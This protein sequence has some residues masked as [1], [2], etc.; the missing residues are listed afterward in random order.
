MEEDVIASVRRVLQQFFSNIDE[1]RETERKWY[2]CKTAVK[3]TLDSLRKHPKII[4]NCDENNRATSKDFSRW[5]FSQ[6]LRI[7]STPKCSD[8]HGD[9]LKMIDTILVDYREVVQEIIQSFLA[10]AH[11]RY[12]FA[13]E[14]VENLK[15]SGLL[16]FTGRECLVQCPT[17]SSISLADEEKCD[18]ALSVI[19]Y[20]LN[21]HFHITVIDDRFHEPLLRATGKVIEVCKPVLKGEAMQLAGSVLL[22]NSPDFMTTGVNLVV[23]LALHLMSSNQ[24]FLLEDDIVASVKRLLTISLTGCEDFKEDAF[25]PRKQCK[26]YIMPWIKVTDVLD[27]LLGVLANGSDL[28]KE[29]TVRCLC[30]I[31]STW[32]VSLYEQTNMTSSRDPCLNGNKGWT[33]MLLP[34]LLNQIPLLKQQ[35]VVKCVM[36]VLDVAD[37]KR[38]ICEDSILLLL[39]HNPEENVAYNRK[40]LS[41]KKSKEKPMEFY[42]LLVKLLGTLQLR[43]L[44]TPASPIGGN[45]AV[46]RL[47]VVWRCLVHSSLIHPHILPIVSCKVE[48][49]INTVETAMSATETWP[50][51]LTLLSNTLLLFHSDPGSLPSKVRTV[52]KRL[53][54]INIS[55]GSSLSDEDKARV[56]G[57]YVLL[58][59]HNENNLKYFIDPI[60][61]GKGK[62]SVIP[63]IQLFSQMKKTKVLDC[64]QLLTNCKNSEILTEVAINL[65]QIVLSCFGGTLKFVKRQDMSKKDLVTCL[66]YTPTQ[67]AEGEKESL[68]DKTVRNILTLFKSDN[69]STCILSALDHVTVLSSHLDQERLVDVLIPLLLHPNSSARHKLAQTQASVSFHFDI[70]VRHKLAKKGWMDLSLF[71]SSPSQAKSTKLTSSQKK[72]LHNLK[73]ALDK[74][75]DFK[76]TGLENAIAVACGAKFL[77]TKELL[78]AIMYGVLM[79]EDSATQVFVM[80]GLVKIAESQGLASKT[81]LFERYNV[82][83]CDI[84]AKR[85]LEQPDAIVSFLEEV[86]GAFFSRLIKQTSPAAYLLGRYV[87]HILPAVFHYGAQSVAHGDVARNILRTLSDFVNQTVKSLVVKNFAHIFCY[88]ARFSKQQESPF[89]FVEDV[90]GMSLSELM[91]HNVQP[92]TNQLALYL[93]RDNDAVEWGLNML[94]ANTVVKD[95]ATRKQQPGSSHSDNRNG[96][97]LAGLIEPRLLGILASLA[98]LQRGKFTEESFLVLESVIELMQIFPPHT[99]TKWKNKLLSILRNGLHCSDLVV[100]HDALTAWDTFVRVSEKKCVGPLVGEIVAVLLPHL[101]TFPSQV[102]QTVRYLLPENERWNEIKDYVGDIGWLTIPDHPDLADVKTKL[103][104]HGRVGDTMTEEWFKEC[105]KSHIAGVTAESSEVRSHS[106]TSL[107][108]LLHNN[109]K[110][111]NLMVLGRETVDKVITELISTLLCEV[112][113][114]DPDIRIL[115]CTCLGEVGAI[116]G[117]LLGSVISTETSQHKVYMEGIEDEKFG[118]D[119]LIV[120]SKGYRNSADQLTEDKFAFAIQEVLSAYRQCGDQ[121]FKKFGEKFDESVMEILEPHINSRYILNPHNEPSRASP[122]FRSEKITTFE[123]WLS[124]WTSILLQL[125][126][127]GESDKLSSLLIGPLKIITSTQTDTLQFL[128]PILVLQILLKGSSSAVDLVLTEI[129]AVLYSTQSS[130]VLCDVTRLIAQTVF[131]LIDYIVIWINKKRKITPKG[132]S[133]LL[134]RVQTTLNKISKQVISVSAFNCGAYNRALMYLEYK[135]KITDQGDWELLQMIYVKMSEF[136][137]VAGVTA[138]RNTPASLKEQIQALETEGRLQETPPMYEQGITQFPDDNFFIQ[139]KLKQLLHTGLHTTLL[140]VVNDRIK[141]NSTLTRDLNEFRVQAAWSLARWD[142]VEEYISSTPQDTSWAVGVGRQ[143][144]SARLRDKEAFDSAIRALRNEQLIPLSVAVMEGGCYER[145]YDNVL[146]LHMLRDIEEWA[147]SLIFNQSS[148][149]DADI[150]NKSREFESRMAVIQDGWRTREPV[151]NLQRALLRLVCDDKTQGTVNRDLGTSWLNSATLARKEMLIPCCDSALQNAS[152]YT[153]PKFKIERARWLWDKNSKE[154]AMTLLGSYL[155]EIK[156]SPD[157]I[158]GRARAE[159]NLLYANWRELTSYYD[160]ED[161]QQ[162]FLKVTDLDPS[163]EEAQFNCAN[164]YYKWSKAVNPGF[165]QTMMPHVIKHYGESLKYGSNNIFQSLPRLLTT[166]FDLEGSDTGHSASQ[167]QMSMSQAAHRPNCVQQANK[168]IDD[169][170]KKLPTYQWL[171]ALSQILSRICH[172]SPSV[173]SKLVEIASLVLYQYPEQTIWQIYSIINNSNKDRQ[174][175]GNEIIK[176]TINKFSTKPIRERGVEWFKSFWKDFHKLCQGLLEISKKDSGNSSTLSISRDFR[177]I[178]KMLDDPRFSRIILPIQQNTTVTLP[179]G[180]GPQRDHQAFPH[181]L[182]TITSLKDEVLVLNSLQRPKKITIVGSNGKTYGL[183]CKPKDDLRKDCRFMEFN[184]MVNRLLKKD[185]AARKKQLHIRTYAVVPLSGDSGIVEWVDNTKLLRVILQGLYAECNMGMTKTETKNTFAKLQQIKQHTPTK[186]KREEFIKLFKNTMLAR[187][188]PVL[189]EWFRRTFPDPSSWFT[190]R[191]KY[192]QTTA[193]I[194]MVGYVVGLGDRHAENIMFDLTNGETVHVDFDCLFEKGESFDWPEKVPFRLTHNLVDAFGVTGVEGTFRLSCVDTMRVMRN[195]KDSLLSVLNSFVHDPLVEWA[196]PDKRGYQVDRGRQHT[197]S[198]AHMKDKAQEIMKTIEKKLNGQMGKNAHAKLP[199][200]TEGQV[201]KLI[202]DSTDVT[203]LSQ[204]YIGW[205]PFY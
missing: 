124:S 160:S 143:L 105:L 106:L 182:V 166:W 66:R 82:T 116:D 30:H 15:Q 180:P 83:I 50:L 118:P 17:A 199:I 78:P 142:L 187:H 155:S 132:K 133:E 121:L 23:D 200:S 162:L 109:Q 149:S 173:S 26:G 137:G 28:Y 27:K 69:Q 167:A 63:L 62:W 136:D 32:N 147:N 153:P 18:A 29:W 204:M 73:L 161:I 112:R 79:E 100:R 193:V 74:S 205:A 41:P 183:L 172:P 55:T 44:D 46:R 70:V 89:T 53:L 52:A 68:P 192:T 178:K 48:E 97:K 140:G 19:L 31:Y 202:S 145:C 154:E 101:Q 60:I 21:K 37:T 64:V 108:L 159:A 131:S 117:G 191:Q 5:L 139:G 87:Q 135:N 67:S 2:N 203:N 169:L 125:V 127:E 102:V 8:I 171:T 201:H 90:S 185:A 3:H 75:D 198:E 12:L 56:L 14:A 144:H 38:N 77:F 168:H 103:H 36:A 4:F 141:E 39:P 88:I 1:V 85:I 176:S 175:H 49:V 111:I 126:V 134:T 107:Q 197:R 91:Q 138:S 33:A 13:D 186:Q 122:V 10:T 99:L 110:I 86:A 57:C 189:S 170:T 196:R 174:R 190:A 152:L 156:R 114:P 94:Q 72:F 65:D 61:G 128:L 40:S 6:L 51:C 146:N 59:S 115:A 80:K 195:E 157:L 42:K 123:E 25:L 92:I 7:L 151:F 84:A 164:Y 9:I 81:E 98:T 188:P 129:Q 58:R 194:S 54:D 113:D 130:T 76:K 120:L 22:L 165:K 119:L 150:I 71:S 95:T 148:C 158:T 184:M 179:V 177:T 47:S 45:P 35:L 34:L 24:L 163:W 20:I 93:S 11:V 16:L 43:V 104:L 96:S 181:H